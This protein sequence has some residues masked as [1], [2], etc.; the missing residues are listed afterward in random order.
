MK[1]AIFLIAYSLALA[2]ASIPVEDRLRLG[3]QLDLADAPDADSESKMTRFE[4]PKDLTPLNYVV[5]LDPDLGKATFDGQ[6]SI[7]VQV[8]TT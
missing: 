1:C 4:L 7:T 2:S 5:L 3:D 6:V 8:G